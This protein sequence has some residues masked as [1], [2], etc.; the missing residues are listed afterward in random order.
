MDKKT[1][2]QKENELKKNQYG[3]PDPTA[4]KA[5]K[6]I[7]D[8]NDRLNKVIWIIRTICELAGYNVEERIVLRDLKTGKIWR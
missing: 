8:E 3:Y 2:I 6:N 4:Y 5:I 1:K 7:E